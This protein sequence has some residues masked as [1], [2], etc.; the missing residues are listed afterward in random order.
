[1]SRTL[2]FDI[3]GPDWRRSLEDVRAIGWEGIFAPDLEPPLRMLVEIGFGRGEFL[4]DLA[5]RRP[6]TA[7]VGVELSFKRTLKLARRLAPGPLRNVRL[8]QA[9]A[10]EVVEDLL[11][12]E[13][14]PTS[15]Q[16]S[17]LRF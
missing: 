1:M 16:Q 8:L 4:A 17:P 7:V 11:G 5:T 12:P 2:K 6:A 13:S 3:P 15:R 14:V 10:E 9:R